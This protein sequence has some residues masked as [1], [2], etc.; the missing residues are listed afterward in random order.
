MKKRN[1]ATHRTLAAYR[2]AN[3]L[4]QRDAAKLFAVSQAAWSLWERGKQRPHS[5][6]VK[7]LVS[8][9]GVPLEVLMGMAS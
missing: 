5:R 2:L 1:Q 3:G 4:S 9:T 8:K 6:Y 7:R